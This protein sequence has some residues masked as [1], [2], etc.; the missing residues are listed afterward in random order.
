MVD[1]HTGY[2]Q[3]PTLLTV[4]EFRAVTSLGLS[5]V[6]DLIKRGEIEHA[7]FGRVVRVPKTALRPYLPESTMYVPQ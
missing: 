2:E 5:T 7:R 3:L 4:R 6:Y 1:R